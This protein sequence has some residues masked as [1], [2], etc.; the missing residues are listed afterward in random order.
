[1]TAYVALLRGINL[2]KRQVKMDA[3]RSWVADAGWDD[4]VTYIASGN[5]VFRG[6]KRASASVAADLEERISAEAGFAIPVVVRTQ[7]E[8]DAV[9]DAIPFPTA[10]AEAKTLHVVFLRDKPKKTALDAIDLPAFAPEAAALGNREVYLHL[11]NGMGRS[12]LAVALTDKT[13]QN[14]GTVR[15]WN[16]VT[17]LA[18]LAAERT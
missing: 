2:G 14:L 4:V 15:N 16:T 9:I 12:K 17:K 11:P 3:L 8:M 6:K 7:A 18:A 13:L 10:G 1:M 5:V